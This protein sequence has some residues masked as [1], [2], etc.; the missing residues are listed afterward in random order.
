VSKSEITIEGMTC[1]HCA[2]TITNELATLEGVVS[3]KVDHSAG[4][5]IVESEGVSQ[6]Q[7]AAAIEEA[8]YQATGFQTLDA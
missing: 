8:G 1:G 5:A 3:V 2:M 7:L 6:E 4:N